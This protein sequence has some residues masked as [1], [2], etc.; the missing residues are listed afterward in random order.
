LF[1]NSMK[2]L[3]GEKHSSLLWVRISDEENEF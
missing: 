2:I 3:G 1:V